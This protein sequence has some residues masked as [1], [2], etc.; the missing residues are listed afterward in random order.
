MMYSAASLAG[1]ALAAAS[2]LAGPGVSVSQGS[3]MTAEFPGATMLGFLASG[4]YE[5]A[6]ANKRLQLCWQ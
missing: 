4:C 1:S 2:D 5:L 6:V 3:L